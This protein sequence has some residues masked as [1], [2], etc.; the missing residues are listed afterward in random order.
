M[1]ET[2]IVVEGMDGSGKS[3]LVAR[4]THDL[5]V[6][7]HPRASDS[8]GGPVKNLWQWAWDDVIHWEDSE[9]SIYDRHPLVSEYIY[10]PV[11]RG[12]M[13][14]VF[15]GVESQSLYRIFQEN[16]LIIF[17]DPGVETVSRNVIKNP[18]MQ[19]VLNNIPNLYWSY[20]TYFHMYPGFQIRWDYDHTDYAQLVANLKFWRANRDR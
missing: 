20:R 11:T 3:S 10:G 19:G 5:Q 8:V 16:C 9:L 12:S 2:V 7:L 4:L 17:C 18:Q 6:P 13:D 14:P 1:G 15:V